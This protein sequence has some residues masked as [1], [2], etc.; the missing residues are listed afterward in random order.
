MLLVGVLEVIACGS[1][2]GVALLLLSSFFQQQ[3]L[4][5]FGPILPPPPPLYCSFG[6]TIL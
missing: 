2:S 6:Q 5:V 4:L 3:L 1:F